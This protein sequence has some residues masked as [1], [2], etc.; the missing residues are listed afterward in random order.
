MGNGSCRDELLKLSGLSKLQG[1]VVDV[2]SD[3]V[4]LFGDLADGSPALYTE[5]LVVA[6]RN[7]WMQ[8]T[9][10]VGN[11][12]YYSN[13]GCSI[14]PDSIVMLRLQE[15]SERINSAESFKNV[16]DEIENW[17]RTCSRPQAVAVLGI[18][19]NSHFGKVMV[20]A[21]YYMKRLVDGSV[22]LQI[23]GFVSLT[24]YVLGKL[25]EDVRN[26]RRSAFSISSVNRFEFYPG[27]NLYLEDS[28][29]VVID[30]CPVQLLTEEEYL[31]H[32]GKLQGTGL[33]DPSA[34]LFARNFS[35][36]YENIAK[37]KPIYQELE[38]LFR[39]VALAK[40]MEFK[41]LEIDLRY[42]LN[43]YPVA[44]TEVD[45]SL[46]GISHVKDFQHRQEYSGGYSIIKLWLPSCGGVR[47]DIDISS[48]NF[49]KSTST[50]LVQL[51]SAVIKFRP[52]SETLFWDFTIN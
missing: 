38:G 36:E 10:I 9:H 32:S 5:D 44:Q 46:P 47:I 11:T 39:F 49:V 16:E 24:D 13:P 28:G 26:N 3:D 43:E 2:P 4:I 19:F 14:D 15:I 42:M 37:K 33:A 12:R 23:P 20:D 45:P 48:K 25:K 52:S 8:Y 6:L 18:P 50:R 51:R 1:Y 29:I 27:E 21:D 7:T 22:N 41:E 34:D 17:N 35:A 40:I 30:K 31:S